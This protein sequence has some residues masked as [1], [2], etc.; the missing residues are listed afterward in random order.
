MIT[1]PPVEVKND[2]LKVTAYITSIGYRNPRKENAISLFYNV[3]KL[4]ACMHTHPL[5]ACTHL[6]QCVHA[7]SSH[8]Q[9]CG[10]CNRKMNEDSTCPQCLESTTPIPRM[11]Y[12][13]TLADHTAG[14][15]VTVRV[16]SDQGA[17]LLG[18]SASKL[19]EMTNEDTKS[20]INICELV[21]P[22]KVSLSVCVCIV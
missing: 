6:T 1:D 17:S 15:N 11:S 4:C 16:F 13:I 8:L 20:L 12:G 2:N 18:V 10:K 21:S 9:A 22:W 5:C 14:G 3:S 19:H 7:H